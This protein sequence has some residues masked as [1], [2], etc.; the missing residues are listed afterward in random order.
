VAETLKR[1]FFLPDIHSPFEDKRY[2]ALVLKVLADWKPYGIVILGD[3]M[4][5]YTLSFHS[6][7]PGRMAKTA[8]DEEVD[9]AKHKIWQLNQFGAKDKRFVCGNH[10]Y[11]LIRY[12]E[13]KAPYLYKT[14][15][16]IQTMLG[17]DQAG[18]KFTP[19][20]QHTRIGKAYVTHDVGVAGKFA[21]YRAADNYQKTI[22]TGH[23]HRAASVISGN[24]AGETHFSMMCGWG[25]VVALRA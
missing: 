4:D 25:G 23:T 15:P 10:E 6:K 24:V 5:C 11:R 1:Y 20:K 2:W 8:F 22:I 13:E 3:F 18:W 16:N 14:H 17:L 12:I 7:D 19:Y 9:D 21:H